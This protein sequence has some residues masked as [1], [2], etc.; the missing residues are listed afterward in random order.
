ML[1]AVGSRGWS[2][3]QLLLFFW[4]EATQARARHSLDQ[5]LYALRT[6]IGEESFAATN[7][8]V[9]NREWISSDVA[10]FA[11]ALERNE[12]AA[13]AKLYRGPFLD[14]FY[15]D[16]APEFE[17]W[18]EDERAR[19]KGDYTRALEQ[20][21]RAA[22]AS[23][24]HV[25][26][27]QWWRSLVASEP[28]SARYA[29]GLIRALMHVGDH[30]AALRFAEQYE[31]VVQ[32]ELGTSVGPAVVNLVAEVRAAAGTQRIA[33]TRTGSHAEPAAG[34]V[35]VAAIPTIESNPPSLSR[36]W[37]SG[38]RMVFLG[39]TVAV[40]AALLTANRIARSPDPPTA[41]VAVLP[42][43]NLSRDSGDAVMVDALTEELITALSRIRT[44]RVTARQSSFTFR[45]STLG[46]SQIADS[47]RVTNLIEGSMRWSGDQLRVQVRLIDATRDVSLWSKSYDL[48]LRDFPM[49]QSDVV[50]AVAHELHL[51]LDDDASQKLR[52]GLTQN[53]AAY[54]L[55]LRGR[56]LIHLRSDSGPMR[57]LSLLAQAVAL[58]STFAA[59]YAAMPYMYFSAMATERD[60]RK[61]RE[62]Q[63]RAEAAARTAIALDA[64]L[65]EGHAALSVALVL[66]FNDLAGAEAALRRAMSLGSAPRLRENLS[67]VL[68]WSGRH[69]EALEEALRAADEDPLSPTAVADLGESLCVNGR[70]EEGLAHL[71]RVANLPTP[72]RRVPG[73]L[74]VCHMMQERWAQAIQQLGDGGGT[75]PFSSLLGFAVARSGDTARARTLERLAMDT[76]RRTGRGAIKVVY[77]AAGLGDIDKAFMWLER[78]SG[79]VPNTTAI[80]YPFFRELHADP[81]FARYRRQVGIRR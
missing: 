51:D 25:S 50:A 12:L 80:M 40:T 57:G 56:D 59:A 44:L 2:R 28:V 14:G 3:D 1:A 62:L 43:L 81:R 33:S 29:A 39:V 32:R 34:G 63:G 74:A 6:S 42:L 35:A 9:L 48:S 26:A 5:L 52:K 17:R 19:R 4:P 79:D 11:A 60:A 21:A 38:R 37:T 68:M 75:D 36:R 30:A 15:L 73:Y 69:A 54:E 72:L 10:E 53:I 18:A 27:V 45:G 20:L 66:R 71:G 78:A 49:L 61:A 55:Y 31:L 23:G 46:A 58:D 70:Y 64:T 24:D 47:L 22:D 41:S 67:R 16:D 65:P 77:I 8:V 76:W 13:A 7:P